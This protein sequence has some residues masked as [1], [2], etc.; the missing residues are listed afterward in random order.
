M[1][2]MRRREF[3]TLLGGAAAWPLAARA[4]QPAMPIIGFLGAASINTV[5]SAAFRKGLNET[6]FVEG[7]NFSIEVRSGEYDQISTLAADLV[8]RGASVIVAVGT[9]AAQS[10]NAAT[11]TIPIVFVMGSDA[12][13]LGLAVSYNRP[14][15][16]VTGVS[17]F[18][19]ELLPKQL[20]LLQEL[21][22]KT[23]LVGVL[24]NPRNPNAEAQAR[25]VSLTAGAI[26]QQIHVANATSETDFEQAFSSLSRARA[27]ALLV[28][29]DGYFNT[30]PQ[31]LADLSIRYKIPALFALQSFVAAGGLMSYGSSIPDAYRQAGVYSGRI[32]KGDRPADLPIAQPTRFELA[33][34]LKTAK[35]L[36]IDVP[37]TL[38]ARA[39][40]VI[41]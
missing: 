23:D 41:E 19:H 7:R 17:T 12:V 15:G 18:S 29:S 40:E 10:A 13:K 20:Q 4:Q 35:A 14:G 26:G 38:L 8:S 31:Q 39:D 5:R 37:P 33:L 9:F 11:R 32:L 3:I 16:N 6:E 28:A 22:G 1:K 21:L 25:E 2:H 34:N 36:G 24:I 30:R 27:D